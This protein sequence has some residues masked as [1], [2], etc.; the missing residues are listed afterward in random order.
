[1]KPGGALGPATGILIVED[2][3]VVARDIEGALIRFGYRV[4]GI[5]SSGEEA[6][7]VARQESP[8]LVLMDIHLRGDLD[9]IE[10]ARQIGQERA[11]PIIFLTAF[12]DRE[13]IER[14]TAT[15]PFG[16]IV[17]PFKE[18][19]LRCQ[20][21]LAL[22]RHERIAGLEDAN[23][24]LE[25]FS[26]AVTHD[27]RAPL[28]R[29]D[30]FSRML[31]EEH[32]DQLP[33]SGRR[34]LHRVREATVRMD[35]VIDDLLR[36]ARLTG[37]PLRRTDVD[38]SGL[39]S[40]I[41]RGQMESNPTRA[42]EVVVQPGLRA[43]C[44]EGLLHLALE[45]LMTNA[46]KFT[47]RTER[48]RIE[49]GERSDSGRGAPVFHVTDNGAGFDRAQRDRL[50]QPFQRL[51][52]EADYPGTGIGLVTVHRIIRRH[53]GQVWAESQPGRGATFFF[54]LA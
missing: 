34:H 20:I 43:R 32:G 9:G 5:A 16:Y 23:R 36:L 21:E 8:G 39:A 40:D 42:V 51:H 52:P 4:V 28:V 35:D 11:V 12:S 50:F 48:P 47:T 30:G 13:T 33:E 18:V 53:G 41:A 2:E 17:K 22:R 24:E 6:I 15:E 46:W 27:L 10:T 49:F 1:M 54:T 25:A 26:A 19:D 3:R 37:L 38:L 7:L 29:I 31:L 45:N 14:A 44:D